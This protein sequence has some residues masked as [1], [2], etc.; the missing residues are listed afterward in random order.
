MDSYGAASGAFDGVLDEVRI[1]S[2]ARTQGEIQSLM[3]A[4]T[5]SGPGLVARWGFG[6]GAGSTAADSVGSIDGTLTNGP[7]WVEGPP[8]GPPNAAP[9]TPVLVGPADTATDIVPP[10]SLEVELTDTDSASVDVTFFGR[11]AEASPT[12]PDPFTIVAYPDTQYYSESYPATYAAQSS[13]VVANES[14]A[15]H[16]VRRTSRRHR[17]E[18]GRLSRQSGTTQRA[19]HESSILPRS[20]TGL[21]LETTTSR[22]TASVSDMTQRSR[23]R[24]S[25]ASHGTA[26]T[27]ATRFPVPLRAF[28]A[29]EWPT[30]SIA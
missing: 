30:Q 11:V 28:Q 10:P 19:A 29:T 4:E 5:T 20:P 26:A 15:Q 3:D 23:R 9:D 6:E 21:S 8:L 17:P 14:A 25:L 1:W 22:P 2:G 27:S 12:P 7:T 16:Q 18:P 13:W 24:D